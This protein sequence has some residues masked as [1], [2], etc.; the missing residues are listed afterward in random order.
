VFVVRVSDAE[1]VMTEWINYLVM[2]SM[3]ISIVDCPLTRRI[4]KLKAVLSKTV[5]KLILSLVVF[6]QQQ[7]HFCLPNKSAI[8]FDGWAEGTDH[9]VGV[10]ASYNTPVDSTNKDAYGRGSIKPLLAD[11]IEGM[12]AHNHLTH[13]ARVLQIFG[14]EASNV[15]CLVRDNCKVNQSLARAMSVPRIGCGIH[16]FNLAVT[17]W[18]KEQSNLTDI[19]AK[20]AA[21]MKKASTLK[22]AAKLAQLTNYACVKENETR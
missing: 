5:R 8:V 2:K 19:I 21:V 13:I 3:V 20:V 16:K 6:V 15:I 9:Y 14:K 17:K 11:G 7:V 12:T 4:S 22:V 18:V 1:M 10:W